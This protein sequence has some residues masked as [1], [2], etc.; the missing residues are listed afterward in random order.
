MAAKTKEYKL[1][2]FKQVLP[3]IDKADKN[4]YNNLSDDE[5]KAYT[6]LVIMRYMS[7]LSDQ[8]KDAAN[9]LLLVN[10]VVNIG[11][12]SLTK[13]T[14]LLHLLLCTAGLGTKQYHPWLSTKGKQSKTKELD[15]FLLELNPGINDIELNILKSLYNKESILQLAKDSGKSDREIKV[16][17][18]DAKKFY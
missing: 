14:E 8:N 10:Y 7:L 13:H 12:W 6:P 5:K 2:L 15:Q 9:Q 1:D 3:S 17:T 11:F 18:D 16:I 4:F